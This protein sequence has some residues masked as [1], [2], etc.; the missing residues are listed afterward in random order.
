MSKLHPVKETVKVLYITKPNQKIRFQIRHPENVYAITG[1]AVTCT[2]GAKRKEKVS[3]ASNAGT[4][5][6]AIAAKGDVAF[7][8][9]VKV[10]SNNY[11]DFTE[12]Q[13][14][15]MSIVKGIASEGRRLSYF[16]TEYKITDAIME[17]YYE[18]NFLTEYG[19]AINLEAALAEAIPL[20]EKGIVII[21]G[22]E[23]S[24]IKE[25][26]LY[27]VTVYIRYSTIKPEEP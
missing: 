4:L 6:L 11:S 17:G 8:E 19:Y 10:D 25:K 26:Q 23:I 21:P 16:E 5:H 27:K 15:T 13:T 12:G 9:D 7:T 20:R 18:D 3:T 2:L 14:F 24:P 22:S 1:I